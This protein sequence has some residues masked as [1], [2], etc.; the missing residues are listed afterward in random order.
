LNNGFVLTLQPGERPVSGDLQFLCQ[1]HSIKGIASRNLSGTG[2]FNEKNFFLDIQ[3]RRY[4]GR[5]KLTAEDVSEI[6]SQSRSMFGTG[7]RSYCFI[8]VA[9]KMIKIPI[10]WSGI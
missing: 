4:R 2:R 8:E 6:V 9:L 7:H 1:K 5:L 3:M 10:T